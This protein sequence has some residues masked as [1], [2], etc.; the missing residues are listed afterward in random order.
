MKKEKKE[1]KELNSIKANLDEI[2]MVAEEKTNEAQKINVIYPF[3]NQPLVFGD[4]RTSQVKSGNF[5]KNYFGKNYLMDSF[6]GMVFKITR[7]SKDPKRAWILLELQEGKRL[8]FFTYVDDYI[9]EGAIIEAIGIC[10]KKN[11]EIE[12][13]EFRCFGGY[14]RLL[15]QEEIEQLI[16]KVSFNNLEIKKIPW[17]MIS[18]VKETK[19]INS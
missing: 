8:G 2:F 15:T 16:R 19:T 12:F 14:R 4:M 18:F 13:Y 10:F 6:T 17:E 5:I 3:S 1:K 9:K 7:L 11:P